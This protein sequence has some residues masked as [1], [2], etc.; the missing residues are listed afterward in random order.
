MNYICPIQIRLQSTYINQCNPQHPLSI[1]LLG[2]PLI[3]NVLVTVVGLMVR[4]TGLY[5]LTKYLDFRSQFT[6]HNLGQARPGPLKQSVRLA[7]PQSHISQHPIAHQHYTQSSHI[8][9]HITNTQILYGW[10]IKH[11]AVCTPPALIRLIF[12]VLNSNK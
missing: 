3:N 6:F 9:P 10:K 1:L 12:S 4:P 7:H 8:P 5:N 2:R 11:P